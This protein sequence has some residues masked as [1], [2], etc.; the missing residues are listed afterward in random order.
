MQTDDLFNKS[1]LPGLVALAPGMRYQDI[2]TIRRINL[3]ALT[4]KSGSV[5]QLA[6]KANLN[7]AFMYTL[8]SENGQR[9][10]GPDAAR[11]IES[12]LGLPPNWMDNDHGLIEQVHEA[13]RRMNS[14]AAALLSKARIDSE[15]MLIDAQRQINEGLAELK[16]RE[17]D[18]ERAIGKQVLFQLSAGAIASTE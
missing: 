16:K 7:L 15:Q 18:F 6:I 13:G 10:M 17:E 4:T 14:E 9:N 12:A 8:R 2:N 11:A 3:C 5:N 1:E